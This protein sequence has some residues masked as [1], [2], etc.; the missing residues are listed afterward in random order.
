MFASD[1]MS[2]FFINNLTT[3]IFL[4]S[5]CVGTIQHENYIVE[6]TKIERTGG[7]HNVSSP[8]EKS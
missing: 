1:N 7:G 2:A 3:I 4:T 8:P 6:V 5:A